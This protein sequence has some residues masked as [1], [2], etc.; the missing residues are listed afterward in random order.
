MLPI[1]RITF[2]S[3]Q[4]AASEISRIADCTA[5]TVKACAAPTD[6]PEGSAPN[7]ACSSESGAAM[8]FVV[9]NHPESRE[10]TSDLN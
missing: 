5:G 8:L 7:S 9:L 6:R 10:S 1:R 4:A 3:R 2:N